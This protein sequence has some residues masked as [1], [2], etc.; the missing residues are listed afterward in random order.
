[1]VMTVPGES[2]ASR[3]RWPLIFEP[4]VEPRSRAMPAAPSQI[5]S[6]CLR[7]AAL[8]LMRMPQSLPRPTVVVPRPSSWRVPSTSMAATQSTAPSTREAS[9]CSTPTVIELS[10]RIST[11]GSPSS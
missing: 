9:T 3:N 4:F 2:A 6:R 11:S 7:D 1:M 8:S 10:L 5:S